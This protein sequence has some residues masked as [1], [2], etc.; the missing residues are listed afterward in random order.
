M[1]TLA[2][3]HPKAM[4]RASIVIVSWNGRRLLER[5]LPTVL[6]QS[7]SEFEVVLLDNGSTDGSAEWVEAHYPSLRLIRRDRNL[8]FARANNQAIQAARGRY[9]ATL[10][11]DAEPD[12]DWLD[13]MVSALESS[14]TVGM[15]ASRMVRADDPSIVDSCGIEVDRAGIGWNRRGGEV[16]RPEEE[17]YEVFGP[18]AGAA[19]YR[20]AMLDQVGMFDADFFAGYEDIDLA[21]RAGRMGWR[22]LYVPSARVVHRHSSTFKE[23]SPLKG[24]LLG[25]NKVW[26]LIKNYPWPQWLLLSPLILAYD[27]AAWGSA[28]LAGDPNPLRGRLAAWKALPR[29]LDKRRSIQA[30]GKDLALCPPRSPVRMWRT[31]R[32]LRRYLAEDDDREEGGEG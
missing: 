18:C 9:V 25:R 8:G 15:C 26:T 31:Q 4:A 28:L 17:P 3:D 16:D 11:N 30:A 32:R 24:Y 13:E 7:Y 19:L 10:N 2:H 29:I 27:T 21:W 14:P 12:P 23:G 5:C 6:S 22:C 1:P 20:R